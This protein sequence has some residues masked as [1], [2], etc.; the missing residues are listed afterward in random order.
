MKY[1]WASKYPK[2][3]TSEMSDKDILQVLLKNRSIPPDDI[4]DFLNPTNPR[5]T[6]P[7]DFGISG[8]EVAKAKKIIEEIGR[9][10]KIIVYGDYDVD[11]LTA[12]AILWQALWNKDYDV[13]PFIPNRDDGYGMKKEIIDRLID[14]YPDLGLII[15]VDNGIVANDEIKYAQEKGIKV[16][17][18]DHHQPSKKI[19]E[20]DAIVHTTE[21]AGCA[22]AW[23][24][25]REFGYQGLSLVAMGT[26]SDM[27]PLTG[28]NRSFVKFGLD[29][30]SRSRQ[31]GIRE[32]KK[33]AGVDFD[34]N[35]SPWQVSFILGPRLNAAGRIGDPLNSL[36]LLCT[37]NKSQAAELAEKLNTV[38]LERQEMMAEANELAKKFVDKKL[39]KLIVIAD[40]DFHPGI[41]GLIA[42]NL[43]EIYSRPAIVISK[44]S[45]ISKGSARSVSGISIV[46]LIR[47]VSNDL[48]DVG[49]HEQAAG[50]SVETKKLDE[51]IEKLT[52]IGEEVISEDDLVV[53]KTADF[54]VD[55]SMLTKSF[56]RLGQKL[57]PFGVGNPSP[58]YLLRNARVVKSQTV[59][60]DNGH[61]KLWLDDPETPKVER[62][63]SEAKSNLAEAIG[64]GWGAWDAKISPGDCVNLVFNLNLNRWNGRETLQLKIKDI[65][66]C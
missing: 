6:V 25:A 21:I 65:E 61:L 66:L 33:V 56:F 38:N 41:I 34:Q 18:T 64:F 45:R 12:S 57:A 58:T 13:L 17:L 28:F 62:I 10:K 55:F 14:Q 44:G 3:V 9:S 5:K 43:T 59:G 35:L 7:S 15:T 16:I 50:F 2:K 48:I 47:Q 49:G 20:A 19:P 42:G 31:V 27:M 51:I 40:E 30:L 11:G 4:K 53:Q 32:L 60:S 8:Q 1:H 52:A 39:K 23:N 46:D 36:R 24:L 22:V 37:R 29:E 54:E 63:L 26:I